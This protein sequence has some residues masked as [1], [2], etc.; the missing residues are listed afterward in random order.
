MH[1]R[2]L[3]CQVQLVQA[4]SSSLVAIL[5][6]MATIMPKMLGACLSLSITGF[7]LKFSMSNVWTQAARSTPSPCLGC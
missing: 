2:R 1:D 3:R 5:A 6:K 4:Q 7:P